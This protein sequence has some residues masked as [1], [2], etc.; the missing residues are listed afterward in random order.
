M[1]IPFNEISDLFESSLSSWLGLDVVYETIKDNAEYKEWKFKAFTSTGV[2]VGT[3][4]L[5]W[6]S[7][8]ILFNEQW[9][10]FENRTG[11]F[12]EPHVVQQVVNSLS[13]LMK[14]K[15]EKLEKK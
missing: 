1:K 9:S 7:R 3:T 6:D 12:C 8:G 15:I 10:F 11:L 13:K 4:Y 2:I 14:T 5:V